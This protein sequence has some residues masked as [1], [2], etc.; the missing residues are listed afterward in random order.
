MHIHQQTG[1]LVVGTNTQ[2]NFAQPLGLGIVF[3]YESV[4]ATV[5]ALLAH[6][7]LPQ[8]INEAAE[9]QI[10]ETSDPQPDQ[11]GPKASGVPQ[12]GREH[13]R[14]GAAPHQRTYV[15]RLPPILALW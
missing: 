12:T 8:Q 7:G 11:S 15:R 4:L 9:V 1:Q 10:T 6:H 14:T 13:P 5:D 3:N 2:V